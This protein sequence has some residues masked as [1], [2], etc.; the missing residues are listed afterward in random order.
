MA[1]VVHGL[2]VK[3]CGQVEFSYLDIDDQD[4]Q[5]FKESL[6]FL[7]QP[8]LFLLD[9][10]GAVIAQWLGYVSGEELDAAISNAVGQ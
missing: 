7:Y 5:V 3:Y 4:T 1:P 8:H 2:E 9:E 10:N 6:G